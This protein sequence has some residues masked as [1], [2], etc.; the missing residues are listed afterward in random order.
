[1]QQVEALKCLI[2]RELDILALFPSSWLSHRD[3][4]TF[5][6]DTARVRASSVVAL[7]PFAAEARATEALD[8][9]EKKPVHEG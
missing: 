7:H 5:E 8:L 4:L 3:S 6:N 9:L 2:A 1:L